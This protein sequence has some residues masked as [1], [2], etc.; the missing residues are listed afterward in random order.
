MEIENVEKKYCRKYPITMTFRCSENDR[1]IIKIRSAET[2]H[3]ISTYLRKR[4]IGGRTSQPIQDLTDLSALRQHLGLLKQL[5]K[6]NDDIRP[7]LKSIESLI[8]KMT[9]KVG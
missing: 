3:S 4:A 1:K 8:V 6:N 2:G 9:E 7:L 5:V